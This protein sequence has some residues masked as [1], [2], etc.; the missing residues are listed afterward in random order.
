VSLAHLQYAQD[1]RVGGVGNKLDE[2]RAAQELAVAQTQ[3]A[4]ALGQLERLQ[5]Q[6]GVAAG[7]ETALD[8][9]N[10]EPELKAAL[11]TDSD[12]PSAAAE[13]RPD[14]IA[15]HRRAQ[16]AQVATEWDW[17]DYTPLLAAVVQPGYQNPPTSTLP[18]WNFQAQVVLSIPL[19]DGG[20]R[21]GQEKER[22]ALRSQADAQL[23][24]VLRQA[25]SEVRAGLMLVH[26]AD[27]AL[28][29][30]RN[31]AKEANGALF[32]AQDA[33]R[34][35]GTTNLEVIDAER[36]ARDAETSVAVAED[37]SRQARLELL[38]ASG[39]FPD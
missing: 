13:A 34:A 6:L 4:E 22:R 39:R 11:P 20:L 31:A 3:L 33:F 23:E 12:R 29:A 26:R 1:R 32:L 35:G 36:R 30:A 38:G 2:A 16:A 10:G 37:A 7:V 24:G 15:A 5:E 25:T 17:S 21:Y 9:P 19:F 18:R 27:E 14:V 8:V 28:V